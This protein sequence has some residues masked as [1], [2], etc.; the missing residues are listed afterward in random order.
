MDSKEKRREAEK[1]VNA[2][3][4]VVVMVSLTMLFATFFLGYAVYRLSAEVWPPEEW[5]RI[6]LGV[7]TASTLVL[8]LS[9]LTYF[10]YEQAYRKKSKSGIGKW[11]PLTFLLGLLFMAF[12]WKLWT[13]LKVV[14]IFTHSNVF[15]SMLYG[16]TWVHAAHV[17]VGLL[18]LLSLLPVLKEK[19]ED[20]KFES[21]VSNVGKFWHFLGGT[22]LLLYGSFFVF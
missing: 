20:N 19:G 11:W 16:F 18:A 5:R 17:L 3:A 8:V 15:S 7:P 6:D 10:F 21:R 14:G 12:Q 13:S 9:S 2:I 4:M 1:Q 22:W